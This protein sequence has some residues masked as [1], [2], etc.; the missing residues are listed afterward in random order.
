MD[1]PKKSVHAWHKLSWIEAIAK[2]PRITPATLRVA[3]AISQRADGDGI[4]R[5]ASQDWIA[6][7]VG[8]GERA[9]RN[10]IGRLCSA[11]YLERLKNGHRDVYGR[12]H[13]SEFRLLIA[14]LNKSAGDGRGNAGS[15]KAEASFRKPG[16][17]IP[18]LPSIPKNLLR[19]APT[20]ESDTMP[21]SSPFGRV[22]QAIKERLASLRSFGQDKVEAW[23][24]DVEVK[25]IAHGVLTLQAPSRFKASHISRNFDRLILNAWREI[26]PD[27]QSVKVEFRSA[28]KSA[29]STPDDDYVDF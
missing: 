24:D 23:L 18:P 22:W 5:T 3:V 29:G 15:V 10:C 11:G 27:A 6:K 9:V 25:S 12:G 8:L 28:V 16:N 26:E 1:R 20:D 4:A 7:H 14:A 13:A 17:P 2:D 21:P 19:R